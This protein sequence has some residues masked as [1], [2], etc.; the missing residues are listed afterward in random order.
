MEPVIR[1]EAPIIQV[2]DINAGEKLGYGGL[3]TSTR[4]TKLATLS[5][6]YADGLMRGAERRDDKAGGYV[7][8][9]GDLCPILGRV[10]MDLL[11]ID[12]T[13][14]EPSSIQRGAIATIIGDELSID[15]VGDSAG[16]IGYDV[17]VS[18]GNRFERRIIG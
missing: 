12:V 3:Y 18:L 4:P 8:I 17:L 7:L 10:S 13:D 15:A 1:L 16:T 5:I 14:A 11:I 9:G 6:G 2:R